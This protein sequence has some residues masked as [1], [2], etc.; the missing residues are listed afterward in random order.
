MRAHII[1]KPP[2]RD[3]VRAAAVSLLIWKQWEQGTE[4]TGLRAP[5]LWLQGFQLCLGPTWD[6]CAVSSLWVFFSL[7]KLSSIHRD[8]MAGPGWSQRTEK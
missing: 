8:G 3:E 6:V 4:N 1:V 2:E 5:H 7:G